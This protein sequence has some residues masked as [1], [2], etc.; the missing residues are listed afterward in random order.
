MQTGSGCREWQHATEVDQLQEAR[1]AMSA[2]KDPLAR[3]GHS[4]RAAPCLDANDS[5]TLDEM[6]DQ[7]FPDALV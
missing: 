7:G 4:T 3:Y 5:E 1:I 6:I 2:L